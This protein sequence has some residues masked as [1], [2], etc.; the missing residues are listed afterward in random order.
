[1]HFSMG[2]KIAMQ[3]SRFEAVNKN[4]PFIE[5]DH[6]MLGILSLEKIQ[7]LIRFYSEQNYELLCAE[8]DELFRI[9][10]ANNLNPTL[11]R[12]RLRI[13]LPTGNCMPADNVYRRSESCK[14]MFNHALGLANNRLT[15]KYLFLAIVNNSSSLFLKILERLNV[16]IEFVRSEI[17]FS[18]GIKN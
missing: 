5:I 18:D 3:I 12:R 15:I 16:D 17:M 4:T 7:S 13:S 14:E 1:M 6:I 8:T 11:L 9:L 2:V 10:Y